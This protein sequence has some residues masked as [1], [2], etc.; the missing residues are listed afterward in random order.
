M[1]SCLLV[2]FALVVSLWVACG[3]GNSASLDTRTAPSAAPGPAPASVLH[4]RATRLSLPPV[5]PASI[6]VPLLLVA[7]SAGAG[8]DP[9]WSSADPSV[10]TID[11]MG[12]LTPLRA[13]VTR[14]SATI[15]QSSA[16][17]TVA[18]RGTTPIP[19]RSNLVGTN[20]S[21]I[22]YYSRQ[23]PFADMMK[24][25]SGWTSRDDKGV[26]GAPFPAMTADGYPAALAPGQRATSAVGWGDANYPV[27]RYVVLWDGVGK[28]SVPTRSAKVVESSAQR[29]A[30]D[31]GDNSEPL[32]VSIDQTSAAQPVR[33]LRF[34][35]PGTEATYARQPFTP[36]FLRRTAPFSNLRFMDWG[37]TN[38]SAVVEWADRS[39]VGDL[40]YAD[41]KGGVPLEVMIELAN[42]LRVDPWFCIPHQASDDYVLRFAGLLRD[43]LD[44][45]LRPHIEYSNEMWNAG[46]EQ[47]KWGNAKSDAL[48]LPRPSGMPS[49]FYAER[50]ARIFGLVRQ[51]YGPV[52]SQRL[53][54]VIAGQA[55][56]S[57]FLEEALAWK[58]TAASADVMAI[59][60]YF[61]LG[62]SADPKNVDA[63]LKRSADQIVDEMVTA[64]DGEVTVWVTASAALAKKH[65]L[66]LMAYEAGPHLTSSHFPAE[67]IDAVTALF[68]SANRHPRMRAVYARYFGLWAA[69]GGQTMNQYND[70]G[71]W[72]KW[73]SWG[74]MEYLLQPVETAPKYMGLMD[75]IAAHPAPR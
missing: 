10:A 39:Q 40:T 44:P 70:I 55:A 7:K 48:G 72:S 62:A 42:T 69:K 25:G 17:T 53:V 28:V 2:R 21:G 11:S 32:L 58:S 73:G 16:T 6:G 33:N 63:T 26:T 5:T 29:L 24:S 50:S 71:G 52:D 13:G 27:G 19:A 60:P 38:G 61:N 1:R 31:V 35:W 56:W 75:V 41:A 14:V 64:I 74:A 23:F 8:G 9:T 45:S 49:A 65:G 12:R 66:R 51:V 37:R 15:G 4:A 57:R 30:V 67:R 68:T 46:F 20:P 3:A 59:A 34:L 22:A 54:R 36:E 43:K 47:T 18:V